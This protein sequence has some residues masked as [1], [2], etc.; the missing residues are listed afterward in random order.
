MKR[1][2]DATMGGRDGT[3]KQRTSCSEDPLDPASIDAFIRDGF[4]VLRA[5]FLRSSAHTCRELLWHRLANDGITKDPS[6]WVERH[7]IA[8]LYSKEDHAVYGDMLS[9]RLTRAIDQLCGT[10]R[11]KRFDLGWWMITFPVQ[12]EPPWGAAGKWHVDGASYQHHV[13]SKESGLVAIFLLS[14]IGPT[15]GGTALAVGSHKRV[16][17]L[18]QQSEPHG[19]KG[20]TLSYQARQLQGQEIREVTGQAGDVVLLHPFLLHARSKNL[21]RKGVDSVRIICN[22]NVQL[23]RKMKLHRRD[24][25]LS[26][27]ERAIVEALEEEGMDS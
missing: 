11:W 21:G 20:G 12:A 7:G 25:R 27:V 17:K 5:A 9:R 16:A 23:H 19:M 18:L 26:P 14:D 15:E 13:D 3:K 4:V 8:E 1:G 10:N 22:P 6:T 24:G 2:Q